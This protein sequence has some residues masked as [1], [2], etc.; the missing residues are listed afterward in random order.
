[1]RD[2]SLANGA[3]KYPP[4]ARKV[5]RVWSGTFEDNYVPLLRRNPLQRLAYDERMEYQSL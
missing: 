1:M 3:V 4:L 5:I 2:T